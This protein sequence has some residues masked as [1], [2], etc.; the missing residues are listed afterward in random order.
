VFGKALSRWPPKCSTNWPLIILGLPSLFLM[1][2]CRLLYRDISQHCAFFPFPRFSFK[3]LQATIITV[4]YMLYIRSLLAVATFWLMALSSVN[5]VS[6]ITSVPW[7]FHLS[8]HVMRNL[9]RLHLRAHTLIVEA[10]AW[11]EDGSCVCDQCPGEDEHVQNEMHAL[12][13]CQV[14]QN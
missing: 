11:H 13:F 6:S 3:V 5:A 7:F 9:S 8:K 2:I 1:S 10:A 12:L 14:H 4:C